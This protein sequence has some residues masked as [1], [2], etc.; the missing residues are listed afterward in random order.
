MRNTTAFKGFGD[1][2]VSLN[3]LKTKRD[4]V[5]ALL[6]RDGSQKWSGACVSEF[7]GWNGS[8]YAENMLARLYEQR[9]GVDRVATPST[10]GRRRYAYFSVLGGEVEKSGFPTSSTPSQNGSKARRQL[11]F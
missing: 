11:R 1:R 2:V 5:A 10:G 9:C 4:Q 6:H 3:E 7:F 8:R